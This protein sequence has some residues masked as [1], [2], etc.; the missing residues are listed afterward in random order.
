MRCSTRPPSA[1]LAEAVVVFTV[2]LF[3]GLQKMPA[4][5][6]STMLTHNPLVLSPA[7]MGRQIRAAFEVVEGLGPL[8]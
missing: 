6:R 1:P 7:S 4:F 8:E 5:W 3:N 2:K